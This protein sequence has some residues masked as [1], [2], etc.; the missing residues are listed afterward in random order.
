MTWWG[1]DASCQGRGWGRGSLADRRCLGRLLADRIFNVE[2]RIG[3]NAARAGVEVHQEAR[4]SL[5]VCELSGPAC[6]VSSPCGNQL[7]G[8]PLRTSGVAGKYLVTII[9]YK[10]KI[11]RRGSGVLGVAV[12]MSVGQVANATGDNLDK[13]MPVDARGIIRNCVVTSK[14]RRM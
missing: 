9:G 13:L 14:S 4:R 5:D 12:S 2:L 3:D 8:N 6:D 1:S 7:A 10:H 11:V